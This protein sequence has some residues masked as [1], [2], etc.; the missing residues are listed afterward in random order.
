MPFMNNNL[1]DINVENYM[2]NNFEGSQSKKSLG[3]PST[4]EHGFQYLNNDYQPFNL[5]NRAIST[6]LENKTI[7]KS[8][9]QYNR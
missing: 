6:R 8:N 3:F 5:E 1:R 4:F 2:Y 9:V 7:A